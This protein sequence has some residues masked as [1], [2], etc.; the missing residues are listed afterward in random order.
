MAECE[1]I[2]D[3]AFETQFGPLVLKNIKAEDEIFNFSK[4][5]LYIKNS[6]P[7]PI[8]PFLE[9][10][11]LDYS[12]GDPHFQDKIIPEGFPNKWKGRFDTVDTHDISFKLINFSKQET[13]IILSK[14]KEHKVGIT[15]YIEVVHALTLQ[16]IFGDNSFTTHRTA[17]TLR[18]HYTLIWQSLLT[19][20]FVRFRIQNIWNP[21]SY[22]VCSEFS[23]NKVFLGIW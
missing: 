14:C 17:M 22:G 10:I 15:S 16:P 5:K 2:E 12:F 20:D 13:K 9:D 3:A 23:T 18:R 8:D 7:P 21:G 4:D 6:L 1:S 11:D 19:K